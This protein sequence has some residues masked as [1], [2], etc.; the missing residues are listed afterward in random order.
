MNKINRVI[1]KIIAV[2]VLFMGVLN[3]IDVIYAANSAGAVNGTAC[4]EDNPCKE[5]GRAHV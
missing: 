2:I 4:P 5:I 1:T 3:V